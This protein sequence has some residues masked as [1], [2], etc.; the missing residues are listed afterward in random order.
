MPSRRNVVQNPAGRWEVLKEGHLRAPV[1]ADSQRV[2]MK[3]AREQVRREGGGEVRVLDRAG[4]IVSSST[5]AARR[6]DK[7]QRPA[8]ARR[9]A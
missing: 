7:A 9:A 6:T 5:V 3:R 4:K 2:A 1:S 8:A